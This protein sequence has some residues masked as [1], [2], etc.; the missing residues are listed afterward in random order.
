[1][2]G[3]ESWTVSLGSESERERGEK[4]GKEVKKKHMGRE[5]E[6]DSEFGE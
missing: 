6:L 2:G 3:R 5:G 1:M 4:V